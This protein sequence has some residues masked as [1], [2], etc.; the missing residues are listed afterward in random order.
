MS[1]ARLTFLLC[2]AE[3]LS[4]TSFAA[5]PAL[6]PYFFDHWGLSG[7]EAGW[8]NGAYFFGF[9]T[10]GFVAATLTDRI[11][12]RK[13]VIFGNLLALIGAYG[14]AFHADGFP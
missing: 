2:L 4:M 5:F 12:A 10:V 6:T 1:A 9:T 3:I 8:I 14:F 7:T 11:D 13:I